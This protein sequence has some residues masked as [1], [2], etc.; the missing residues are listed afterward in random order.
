VIRLAITA[1][2]PEQHVLAKA[3][4]VIRSGGLVVMPTDTLYGI[5]ADP[6]NAQ[7][8]ERVFAAK[9]RGGDQPLPLVAGNEAQIVAQLG[10]LTDAART[11]ASFFWPGPL[12]LLL[13]AP[14]SMAAGVTAGTAR[15]GVRVPAH[16]VTRGLCLASQSLLTATSANRSGQPAVDSADRV[17]ESV[18]EHVDVVLDAGPTVGGLPST[19]IDVTGPELRLVRAGAIPWEAIQECRRAL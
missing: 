12:T 8:V 6:F 13:P 16:A 4:E 5:A 2:A 11:L 3:A 15:V 14:A 7:A 18:S 10:P 1:T 9:G 17:A 19:V